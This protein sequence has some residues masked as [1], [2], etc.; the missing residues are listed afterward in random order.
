MVMM[1]ENKKGIVK[2]FEAA[3]SISLIFTFMLLMYAQGIQKPSSSENILQWQG[4]ILDE[5]KDDPALR[6]VILNNEGD[7][8]TNEN[9][10]TNIKSF[11]DERIKSSF[12]GFDFTCRVCNATEV[13]G[14]YQPNAEVFSEERI[15]S[16]T[17]TEFSPKKIRIFMWK[18]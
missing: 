5:M 1:M 7:C 17:L 2:I 14:F 10:K 8:D 15:V 9:L 3:I 13:C 11:I 18:E 12:P 6:A 4:S 16:A